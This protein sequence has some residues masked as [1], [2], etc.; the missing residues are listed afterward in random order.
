MKHLEGTAKRLGLSLLLCAAGCAPLA[1]AA[2]RCEAE[3]VRQLLAGGEDPNQQSSDG[4]SALYLSAR[5]APEVSRALLEAGAAPDLGYSCADCGFKGYTPLCQELS[6][7]VAQQLVARGAELTPA[8]CSPVCSALSSAH[9]HGAEGLKVALWE[10]EQAHPFRAKELD[11]AIRSL[12]EHCFGKGDCETARTIVQHLLARKIVPEPGTV[13]YRAPYARLAGASTETV[14]GWFEAAFAA[15]GA[16]A[17]AGLIDESVALSAAAAVR[18][19]AL[20][21]FLLEKG[22]NPNRG[23]PLPLFALRDPLD[24]TG[25]Q[26]A[27]ALLAKGA[28]ADPLNEY[29]RRNRGYWLKDELA[30]RSQVMAYLAAK[31]GM[32]WDAFS[33]EELAAHDQARRR[34]AAR[35]IER[36]F[37][38]GAEEY[39]VPAGQELVFFESSVDN[40]AVVAGQPFPKVGVLVSQDALRQLTTP[41]VI[42][43]NPRSTRFFPNSRLIVRRLEGSYSGVLPLSSLRTRDLYSKVTVR[44]TSQVLSG[45]PAYELLSKD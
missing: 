37:G 17:P 16:R 20:V 29:I 32:K 11:C 18:D 30:S 23:L 25:V 31:H 13:F 10:V 36:T 24:E 45:V 26:I 1:T 22:A 42:L 14:I 12:G 35:E 5:C 21:R 44:E 43:G 40:T 38:P 34:N 19:L 28:T 8:A 3:R 39:V 2:D 33:P 4:V 27:E 7:P 15:P 41:R 9:T 6:L